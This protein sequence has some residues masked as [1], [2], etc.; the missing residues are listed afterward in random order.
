MKSNTD[1]IEND[2]IYRSDHLTWV[3]KNAEIEHLKDDLIKL[4]CTKCTAIKD[5]KNDIRK[6]HL[7]SCDLQK[8]RGKERHLLMKDE[9]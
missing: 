9:L 1:L 4:D 8:D 3:A 6:C 7:E 2:R 5:L